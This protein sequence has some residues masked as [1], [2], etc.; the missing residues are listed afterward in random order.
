MK[1]LLIH[2]FYQTKA[3]SG[4]DIVYRN[5]KEILESHG[6][7]VVTYERYNEEIKKYSK[8]KAAVN[9]I[10][11]WQT[12]KDLKKLIKK[13]NPNIAHFH[14]IWYLVS[15]SAYH[16]CKELGIPVI[17]TLHNFRFFCLNGILMREGR[18]CDD[19]IKRLPWKGLLK[20]CYKNSIIFSSP[21]FG[22]FV[23]HRFLKTFYNKIDAF[24][25]P[26]KFVKSKFVSAG[27][28]ENKIF[29]KPHFLPNSSST[30]FSSEEY[31]L[32]LGRISRE[33][34]I[35]VILE[36]LKFLKF[37]TSTRFRIKIVGDGPWKAKIEEQ[38]KKNRITNVELV[39]RKGRKDTIELL[40][41]AKFV[42]IPSR[43]YETFGMVVIEAFSCG[44]PV[45]VSRIGALKELVEE[46]KT[47]LFFEI[48]D[49][50]D[51]AEKIKWMMKHKNAC[52]E[53]GKNA[54]KVFEEKYTAER[55]FQI[56]MDIYNSV[57]SNYRKK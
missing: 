32:F 10:W 35:D 46:G 45:I 33:K 7:N 15:P 27:F 23:V 24:I 55:N 43:W 2:N 40:K 44:K 8:L 56:L 18:I 14:N 54:R 31:A 16:A 13:E 36:S 37:E 17:Q 29:I 51:L 3:P 48:D 50:R 39:G 38:I 19:C 47:G 21:I 26:T 9:V 34:G 22:T 11:S 30:D 42:I 6:V 4:E 25:A 5:E 49:P 20:G 57:L 41:K 52:L 1:V 53:M 12:Y 28:I